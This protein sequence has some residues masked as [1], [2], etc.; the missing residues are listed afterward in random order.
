MQTTKGA[1]VDEQLALDGVG[2]SSALHHGHLH[3]FA[4]DVL[5]AGAHK[6]DRLPEVAAK[7]PGNRVEVG[8]GDQIAKISSVGRL[9]EV[10]LRSTMSAIQLLLGMP[11]EPA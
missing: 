2:R 3:L 8:N 6:G 9:V 4:V 1:M 5:V 10:D 11:R 7:D